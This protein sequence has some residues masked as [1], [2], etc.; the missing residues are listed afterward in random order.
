MYLVMRQIDNRAAVPECI[1]LDSR[2]FH[3]WKVEY[4]RNHEARG[5]TVFQNTRS[6]LIVDRGKER[7]HYTLEYYPKWSPKT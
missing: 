2:H 7:V 1:L 6:I 5:E 4:L 3:D